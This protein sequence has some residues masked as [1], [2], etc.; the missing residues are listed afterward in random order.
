[1]TE[2][3]CVE[4]DTYIC[5]RCKGKFVKAWSDEEAD[6]EYLTNFPENPDRGIVCDDCYKYLMSRLNMSR[7]IKRARAPIWAKTPLLGE[8]ADR[9]EA[10][11]K[12]NDAHTEFIISE[13]K[14]LCAAEEV[15]ESARVLCAAYPVSSYSIHNTLNATLAA[16]DKVKADDE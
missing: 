9:I 10:L 3:T 11:E 4:N 14:I 1:M 15:V 7:L 12:E 6:K 8:L 16:Y 5:S 13:R 2:S